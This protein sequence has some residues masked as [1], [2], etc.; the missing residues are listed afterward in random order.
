MFGLGLGQ[1]TL[2]GAPCPSPTAGITTMSKYLTELQEEGVC[3]RE[4]GEKVKP[5]GSYT[6]ERD[7]V[8]T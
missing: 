1:K 4:M 7:G 2:K 5:S 8:E 6:V 3:Q